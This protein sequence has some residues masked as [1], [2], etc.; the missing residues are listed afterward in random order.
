MQSTKYI[1]KRFLLIAVIKLLGVLISITLL[2]DFLSIDSLLADF[3]YRQEGNQW[4]LKN[5]WVTAV[6]IHKAGKY[7]SIMLL[8]S[9]LILM[10]AA[11]RYSFLAQWKYRLQF[12]F[13]ATALATLFISIGKA[14]TNI[15]CPWDFAR[16][17]GLVEYLPLLKQLWIRNGSQCFPAGH[18]SAGF[19][20]VSLYF[21]GRSSKAP[22]RWW[23]L[24]FAVLMGSL[25]GISQQLRGAHFLSHDLWSFGICWMVS[26]ICYGVL[27]K[28]YESTN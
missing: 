6:F 12:L 16:Y 9:V 14:L 26:L 21:M 5:A 10:L 2:I 23:G 19:A 3:I 8:T 11:Y 15:S 22:W 24:G 28:P 17:G 25:F 1:D 18:A 4:Q 20:W 7:F 27:L 13:I